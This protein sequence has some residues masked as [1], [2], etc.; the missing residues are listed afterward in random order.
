MARSRKDPFE[1]VPKEFKD[2]V[3][4]A[5]DEEINKR[6]A[7]VAKNDAALAE[8]KKK[9]GDLKEKKDSLKYAN[10]PYRDGAK[11]NKQ[12]IAYCRLI[13]EARGKDAGDSGLDDTT[14]D[15]EETAEAFNKLGSTLKPGESISVQVGNR[16]K[17]VLA[18]G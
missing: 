7:E 4:T 6:I 2:A 3:E 11:A 8:A 16:P 9:D 18:E 15:L 10:E 14:G 13:L 17:V 12:R 1:F 5:S